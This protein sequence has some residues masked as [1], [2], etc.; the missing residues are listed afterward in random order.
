MAACRK[1]VFVAIALAILSSACKHYPPT[2]P[3]TPPTPGSCTAPPIDPDRSLV[4]HDPALLASRFPLRRTLQQIIDTSGGTTTPDALLQTLLDSYAKTSFVQPVSGKTFP[5]LARPEANLP[6]AQLLDPTTANGMFPT[7]LFNRFDLAPDDGSNCGEYR[8]VYAKK[9]SG[10]LDRFFII[11]EAKLPNPNTASGLAGCKPVVD[12]WTSLSTIADPVQRI[13]KLE[14]FYYTG[15]AP[16]S[17][18]VTYGNYGVPF[19]QVRSNLFV[20][21]NPQTQPWLLREN[22]TAP[23]STPPMFVVDT[24]K[25]NPLTEWYRLANTLPAGVTATD[26]QKFRDHFLQVP[27]C[28][29]VL[30]DR[31]VAGATPFQIVNNM[32]AGFDLAG[33][34]FQSVALGDTDDPSSNTDATFSTAVGTRLAALT[35]GNVSPAELINRAGAMTCGGCHEFS[36]G[37]SLGNGATWPASNPNGFTHIDEQGN[38]SPALTGDFL[39]R[40]AEILARFFCNPTV[41]PKPG[42]ACTP[43]GATAM[44]TLAARRAAPA[45]PDQALAQAAGLDPA[46]IARMTQGRT[47]LILQQIDT[48]RLAVL[49]AARQMRGIGAAA[50]ADSRR[51]LSGAERTLVDLVEQA[52]ADE[53]ARTGA[54]VP[55]RRPH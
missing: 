27:T 50:A 3:T 43:E 28:N 18:V 14:S 31:F 46:A 19:G 52:R 40:R 39:K 15:L 26:Q 34:E 49:G 1:V 8:I 4:V 12:L 11:F 48:A 54:F 10:G 44:R 35:P 32:G 51:Q 38:L 36:K 5:V 29:L 2:P 33:N 23:A 21:T 16:F 6:V 41:E 53:Q 24:D 42:P 17:P 7:G 22:R 37:R 47:T 25:E 20:V 9:S 30:T 13:T 45:P 55:V